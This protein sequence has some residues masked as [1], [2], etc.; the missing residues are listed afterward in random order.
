MHREQMEY[1][2][3]DVAPLVAAMRAYLQWRFGDECHR[4]LNNRLNADA[5]T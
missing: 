5:Q 4:Q 1:C 2:R 3:V